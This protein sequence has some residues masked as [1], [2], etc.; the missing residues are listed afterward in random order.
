M[1]KAAFLLLSALVLL[2][3]NSN[4]HSTVGKD[5]NIYQFT[6][7]GNKQQAI[8]L[9]EYEGKVL[10]VV[11]T[12][13]HCGFTPQY[14]AMEEV[15]KE[16]KEKGFEILDFPCNQFGEQAPESDDDYA[17]FCQVNYQVDFP[18]F[19][20]IEVN[21]ANEHPLY[22]WLK[23]EMATDSSFNNDIKWNFTKFLINTNGKVVKRYES[24]TTIDETYPDIISLL[25]D[26]QPK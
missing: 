9:K 4:E 12:A 25:V 22:K 2:A 19:H 16:L 10:L 1:K 5:N 17:T 15:Y 20:K 8:S 11:N 23:A 3:C 24:G 21:G 13:S 14:A 6:V 7:V 26:K 18:Q